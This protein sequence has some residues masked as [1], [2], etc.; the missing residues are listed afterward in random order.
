MR[1][2]LPRVK[3]GAG[4]AAYAKYASFLGIRAPCLRPFYEA[5]K[6]RFLTHEQDGNRAFLNNLRRGASQEQ[7]P[8]PVVAVSS[9]DH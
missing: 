8:E 6:N 7:F 4:Y 3:H 9:H 5:V 1:F 2:I